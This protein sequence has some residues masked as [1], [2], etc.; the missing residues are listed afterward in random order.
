MST[1]SLDFSW[2]GTSGAD[3]E[4]E[5]E[6]ME[7]F[8]CDS[9]SHDRPTSV[10]T[11]PP[12][13]IPIAAI[14]PSTIDEKATFDVSPVSSEC[15]TI[16]SETEP[17][18]YAS[19]GVKSHK[20]ENQEDASTN[21]K[22]STATN[23][24]DLATHK[25]SPQ[26]VNYRSEPYHPPVHLPVSQ[27]LCWKCGYPGHLRSA[28][29]GRPILFCSRCGLVGILT[30]DC[31]CTRG[32]AVDLEK[33]KILTPRPYQPYSEEEDEARRLDGSRYEF[34]E[35]ARPRCDTATRFFVEQGVCWRCGYPG[36]RRDE[37][38]RSA[39]PPFCSR[40][41][42]KGIKTIDCK[43]RKIKVLL[44]KHNNRRNETAIHHPA[45]ATHMSRGIQVNLNPAVASSSA[46]C[47]ACGSRRR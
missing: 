17:Q 31:Q 35:T 32:R 23:T 16:T 21:E 3:S 20:A 34:P 12:E 15:P 1:T 6:Q 7:V 37:C 18:P 4:S 11:K 13:E 33:P 14:H 8:S 46:S 26:S 40:C 25:A 28:C 29:K 38:K 41:G 24:S 30:R 19:P 27:N 39:E 10:S 47:P 9:I 44:G 42:K 22:L 45:Y 2:S 36:H 43:C 5:W